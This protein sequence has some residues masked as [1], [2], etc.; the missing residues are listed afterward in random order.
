MYPS[1]CPCSCRRWRACDDRLGAP[2]RRAD[3]ATCHNQ[4]GRHGAMVEQRRQCV[5]C[6]QLPR[7]LVFTCRSLGDHPSEC[8]MFIP[9]SRNFPSHVKC[10]TVFSRQTSLYA[11]VRDI[12]LYIFV[13]FQYIWIGSPQKLDHFAPR[14]VPQTLSSQTPS[15]F[16]SDGNGDPFVDFTFNMPVLNQDQL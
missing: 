13:G 3:G 6:V 12:L 14:V 11:K 8:S 2:R 9:R 7:S 15:P 4:R 5:Q 1:C 10:Q 16:R